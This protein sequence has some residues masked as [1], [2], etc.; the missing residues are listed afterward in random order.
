M[1][2]TPLV[3]QVGLGLELGLK[4]FI[5]KALKSGWAEVLSGAVDLSECVEGYKKGS[6]VMPICETVINIFPCRTFM[7]L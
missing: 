1:M 3:Q 4:N 6:I 7:D 5:R 2:D